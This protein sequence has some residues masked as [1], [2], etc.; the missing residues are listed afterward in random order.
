MHMQIVWLGEDQAQAPGGSL[1]WINV[2]GCVLCF[3]GFDGAQLGGRSRIID[4]YTVK[5]KEKCEM[6]TEKAGRGR[7]SGA[8]LCWSS[9]GRNARLGG[10]RLWT[11][12]GEVV[13]AQSVAAA[14]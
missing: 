2:D 3:G 4:E 13:A 14:L 5:H 12:V 9:V 6:P 10:C 1:R 11:G 7:S 8:G